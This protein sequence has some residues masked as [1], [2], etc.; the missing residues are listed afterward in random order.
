MP[1]PLSCYT[2]KNDLPLTAGEEPWTDYSRWKLTYTEDGGH[3]WKY[4]NDEELK[5]APQTTVE[6]YWLGLPLVRVNTLCTL[7]ITHSIH[8]ITGHQGFDCTYRRV[9]CCS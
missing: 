5:A 9:V 4:L 6:K 1:L 7:S 3:I 8:F 2:P